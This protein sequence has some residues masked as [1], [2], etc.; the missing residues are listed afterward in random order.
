MGTL[1]NCT[2]LRFYAILHTLLKALCNLASPSANFAQSGLTYRKSST[3]LPS[4]LNTQV[5]SARALAVVCNNQRAVTVSN[6]YILEI[7]KKK[8]KV[9]YRNVN[10]GVGFGFRYCMA[11]CVATQEAN[12]GFANYNLK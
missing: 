5:H 1:K 7:S 11:L 4:G 6:V 3:P 10:M 2:S 9:I 12:S 8:I